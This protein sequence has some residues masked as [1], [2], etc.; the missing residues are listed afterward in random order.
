MDKLN[1]LCSAITKEADCILYDL[2]LINVLNRY[3]EVFACGSYYLNLMVWRD[4]DIYVDNSNMQTEDFFNLGYEISSNIQPRKM[5]Y[6][7][8]FIGKTQGLPKGLYWGIYT[9][10]MKTDTWKIDIWAIDSEQLLD[11]KKQTEKLKL[12]IDSYKRLKILEIK[13][14]VCN[15][16]LYR[17]EF[18]SVDIYQAV[19]EDN[20][21]DMRDFKKWLI[22]NKDIY[23]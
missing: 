9:D 10:I 14:S 20:I 3:G 8:E 5:S 22:H 16:P 19:I 6:R 11:F 18:K 15:H 13:N 1:E 2:G 23:L 4:L 17:K 12:H 21:G 7:N